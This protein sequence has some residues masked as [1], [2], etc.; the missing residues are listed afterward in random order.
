[1][2]YL[3]IWL[4]LINTLTRKIILNKLY[5]IDSLT[6]IISYNSRLKEQLIIHTNIK[7]L[8]NFCIKESK[9]PL[10]SIK[11]QKKIYKYN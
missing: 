3:I 8:K 7:F 9:K 10:I 1:M 2:L 5:R 6:R 4:F 11:L